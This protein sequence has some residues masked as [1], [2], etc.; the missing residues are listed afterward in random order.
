MSLLKVD[1][2]SVN[3]GTEG[4]TLKHVSFDI[5]YGEVVGIIGESGS[6]KSTIARAILN[7]LPKNTTSLDGSIIYKNKCLNTFTEKEWRAIRG[8]EIAIIFQ[9][10]S[11]YLNPIVKIKK[12]FIE[13]ITCNK[14]I[15]KNK[16][17][18][19]AKHQLSQM[20]LT[21]VDKILNSYPFELSGGMLQRVMI[22]MIFAIEPKLIIADEP[23]SSLDVITQNIIVRELLRLKEELKTSIIF[24][25]HDLSLASHIADKVIVIKEG[26]IV[27]TG[28]KNEVL[29]NPKHQYTQQLI[30]SVFKLGDIQ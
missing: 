24:I 12:Q 2:L 4:D 9:N 7:I 23:T 3:Y 8:R 25:T 6:G 27:E 30:D 14:K 21:H 15:S 29:K 18:E 26:E 22:A 16:A 10:P 20:N 28:I 13:T 5:A 17:L 19:I 1:S 11:H